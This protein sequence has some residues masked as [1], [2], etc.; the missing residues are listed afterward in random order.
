[1]AGVVS[2][3]NLPVAKFPQV[4][5]PTVQVSAVY[6]GANAQVIAETVAT[7]IEQEVNG[8]ENMLY[9]SSTSSND[10]SYT[11]QIT[12]AVGH[13]YGYGER[14]GPESRGD[15]HPQAAGRSSTS[16]DYH[17]QTVHANSAND[18]LHVRDQEGMDELFL[19]NYALKVKDELSRINGVGS[20]RVFG[21]GDYSM[22]SL[23]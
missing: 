18:Q 16:G 22:R 9:M 2:F 6:P 10:G 14:A 12:F 4:S 11:L 8:V 5:P 3:H 17:D 19:S 13:G 7:A 15:R 20:V 1:M 23:A 21:A